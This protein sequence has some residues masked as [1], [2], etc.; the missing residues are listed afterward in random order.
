MSVRHAVLLLFVANTC[1]GLLVPTPLIT[2]RAAAST[3]ASVGLATFASSPLRAAEEPASIFVGRYTD[4]INHPG[5]FRE[6]S[7]LSTSVGDFQ[8]AE[9]KGGGG[10]GEPASYVLPARV[11]NVDGKMSITI[12]FSP[13]GGPKDFTGIFETK[14]DGT[15]GIRFL[16][17]R[18]FWPKQ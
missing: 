17:D 15:N 9:V 14:E 5:G 10:R 13:K 7:L 18:N 4:P 16:R 12:D 1:S 2:R 11:G 6:I 8:L 3:L